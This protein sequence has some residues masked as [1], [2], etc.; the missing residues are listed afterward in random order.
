MTQTA[1]DIA[2]TFPERL[3]DAIMSDGRLAAFIENA[4]KHG[5]YT[6]NN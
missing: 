3:R 5:Y 2:D 1:E 6:G 4:L